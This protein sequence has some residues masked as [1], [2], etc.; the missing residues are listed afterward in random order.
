[1]DTQHLLLQ[2]DLNPQYGPC[3]NMT[4][5]QRWTRADR[6]GKNP[7]LY[8]KDLLQSLGPD[9]NTRSVLYGRI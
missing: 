8:I 3:Q 2:F 9:Q 1:M 6:L 7:P 4:R 5:L